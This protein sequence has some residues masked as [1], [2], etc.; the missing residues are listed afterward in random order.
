MLEKRG[1]Q[2]RGADTPQIARRV[3]GPEL[4]AD[5]GGLEDVRLLLG[6]TVGAG[7]AAGD[8]AGRDRATAKERGLLGEGQLRLVT[9]EGPVFAQEG[10]YLLAIGLVRCAVLEIHPRLLCSGGTLASVR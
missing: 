8:E 3:H 10:A 7:N 2:H 5:D 4:L 1:D 6:A 9:L